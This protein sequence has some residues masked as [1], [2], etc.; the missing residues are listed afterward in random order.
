MRI[1]L[2]A[3]VYYNNSENFLS[4]SVNVAPDRELFDHDNNPATPNI[5]KIRGYAVQRGEEEMAN[6]TTVTALPDGSR[7]ADLTLSYVNFGQ[8]NT[9]GFD[10]GLNVNL[11][12]GLNGVFN[13][14]YFGYKLDEND[15]KN[16]G[17][18]NGK[19]D[20]NDLAINTPEHKIGLGLNFNRGNFFATAFGRWVTEYDF[21]SGINVAAATNTDLIY[22]GSPVIEGKRVGTSFNNGPLGGF[23]NLDLGVG[24]TFAKRYTIAAQ[25]VN[26]LNQEVRE[27]VASPVIKPL[28]SVEFKVNLPGLGKK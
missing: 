26:V 23:F 2:D 25:V 21:F 13:Y 4:P 15:P 20:E 12:E 9:Y 24:Y 17:N 10:F 7:G 6:F 8:V 28:Y 19:V 16:D 18:R 5:A 14:S 22:A 3:N 1:F 27:F 11:F